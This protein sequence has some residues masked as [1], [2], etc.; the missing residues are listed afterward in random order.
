M[1]IKINYV[2]H[3]KILFYALLLNDKRTYNNNFDYYNN[4]FVF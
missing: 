4:N 3:H 2:T 1:I